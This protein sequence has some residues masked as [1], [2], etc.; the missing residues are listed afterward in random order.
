E[1]GF[2]RTA[3]E[4]AE[5]SASLPAA[6]ERLAA[7]LEAREAA[8]G[9]VRGALVYPSFVLA[10][11]CVVA[12]VML[13][14]VVPR[15]AEALAESGLSMP[16]ASR[17]LVAAARFAVFAL[18][19]LAL[20]AL[21]AVAAAKA[22]A[23]RD[24]AAARALDRFLLRLPLLRAGRLAAA[25][26]F[27]SV[28]GALAEGGMPVPAAMP[29]AA[30]AT[31]RPW[32]EARLAE[33]TARVE[34]GEPLADALRGVPLVGAELAPWARVGEAG[35]CLPAM[36][37]AAASRLR[38]RW[39]RWLSVR[40]ALLEPALLAAVGLFVLL[41]ALAVVLPLPQMMKGLG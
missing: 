25:E 14:F 18:A 27:A 22:R 10:L 30:A 40:L 36:L 33:A 29:L 34:A 20:A 7:L 12:C 11:G 24:P 37:A 38:A 16:A 32:I 8:R 41:L 39:D 35:G 2:E 19:P 21:A 3:V 26:R 15:T 17:A 28:L 31:G 5:R 4:A 6:L 23:R 1:E 9:R 13:G